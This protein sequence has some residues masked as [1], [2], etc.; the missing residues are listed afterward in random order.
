MSLAALAQDLNMNT[1]K[2]RQLGQELATPNVGAVAGGT[3]VV[4]YGNGFA[5][6]SEIFVDG[7]RAWRFENG[8]R[9]DGAGR[10]AARVGHARGVVGRGARRVRRRAG[11]PRVIVARVVVDGCRILEAAREADHGE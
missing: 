9:I 8:A 7:R 11:R 4:L 2:F 1:N 10:F 5:E 3:Y 6:D